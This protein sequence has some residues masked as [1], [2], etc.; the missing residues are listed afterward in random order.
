MK[1]KKIVVILGP[2]ASGKTDLSIK[3][4]KKFGGEI[5]SADSRQVYKGMNIGTGKATKK[6]MQGIPHH[7][8]DVA[9]PKKRFTVAQYKKLAEK[10]IKNI[11]KKGRLPFLV[12]G[13]G[14]YIQA[15]ID[16]III[17]E[18]KPDLKLRKGLEQKSA[19]DLFK[20]LERIDPKRAKNIDKFNKRRLVRALEIVMSSK[21]P[22]PPLKTNPIDSEILI[23]GTNKKDLNKLIYYRLI[24]RLKYGMIA[25]VKRL[26]KQGVSWK[27]LEE[28]GLEYR[29]IALFLQG[30]I[31]KK[32][33]I[34]KLQKE[35]EHYAKRQMTWFKRDKRI[36]WIKNEKQARNL[37]KN[38]T[39]TTS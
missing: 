2:T 16:G 17:P 21:S 26:R 11:Q 30:K 33:M 38:F 23:L 24:K 28:F 32:E 10:A 34:E 3:L 37:L 35:I 22:V 29:Y 1:M 27:R 7:L 31:S 6:E 25:E 15:V 39:S 9:S 4:A 14:F 12:G 13:T 18:V 20:R 8:L 5:V 36:H 19:E